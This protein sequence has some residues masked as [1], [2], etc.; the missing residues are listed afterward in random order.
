M[1][2]FRIIQTLVKLVQPVRLKP[3]ATYG[4]IVVQAVGLKPDATYGV[5][6]S[7]VR[8]TL[9]FVLAVAAS[10][11]LLAQQADRAR[12]E[13]LARR[14]SNRTQALQRE[15]DQLASQE[16]TLL[17]DLRKLEVDRQIKIEQLRQLD[18]E[19]GEVGRDL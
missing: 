3:D 13:A 18:A 10:V 12:T 5:V 2:Q 11:S 17:G 4:I 9:P 15:A 1:L 19:A 8:R 6:A 16:K 7:A 14:A